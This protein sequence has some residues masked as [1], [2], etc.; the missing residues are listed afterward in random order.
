MCHKTV[1]INMRRMRDQNQLRRRLKTVAQ[2]HNHDETA[3]VDRKEDGSPSFADLQKLVQMG[4]SATIG[5]EALRK[6]SNVN[7]AAFYILV[8]NEN[9]DHG[10]K[11][12]VDEMQTVDEIQN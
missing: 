10:Q 4:F 12:T 9:A 3:A 5:M 6:T 8:E 11:Q 2:V 7:A 1:I